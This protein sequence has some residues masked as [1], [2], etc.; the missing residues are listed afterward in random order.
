[1]GS[2]LPLAAVAIVVAFFIFLATQQI[3]RPAGA[4]PS[5][6][7]AVEVPVTPP[8]HPPAPPGD[9]PA[10]ALGHRVSDEELQAQL[11]PGATLAE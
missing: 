4:L 6:R 5:P 3:R 9:A 10:Q 7:S 11:P 8:T 2:L 1:M